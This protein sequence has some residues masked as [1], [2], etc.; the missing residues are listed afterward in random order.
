MMRESPETIRILP[1]CT[2]SGTCHTR[3]RMDSKRSRPLPLRQNG[4][5]QGA[6]DQ[7][8]E[9]REYLRKRVAAAIAHALELQTQSRR[10]RETIGNGNGRAADVEPHP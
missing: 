10:L 9:E 6:S 5:Q 8:V 2:R 1:I 7:R 4:P 3:S